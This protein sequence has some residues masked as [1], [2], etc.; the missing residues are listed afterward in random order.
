MGRE[1]DKSFYNFF[2]GK[3]KQF[4]E[5]KQQKKKILDPRSKLAQMDLAHS[6]RKRHVTQLSFQKDSLTDFEHSI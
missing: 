3:N 2:G 6:L 4:Y 1:F 5:K